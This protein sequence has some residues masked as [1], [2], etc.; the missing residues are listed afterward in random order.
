MRRL[1]TRANAAPFVT[2]QPSHHRRG[3]F[4]LL[5][6]VLALAPAAARAVLPD[7]IQVYANDINRSQDFGLELHLNTTP[8]GRSTP[9][10]PDEIPPAHGLRVTPELSWGL[11]RAFEAGLYLPFVHGAH[12]R[13]RFA[14]PKLRLKWL[15]LH[16][17]EGAA[18]LFGGVNFE[19]AWI[20]P[21]LEQATRQAE[22]RPIVGWRD[23]QWLI[24]LNP[25]LDFALAGAEQ[26][27]R[28]DFN[29]A[30]K[31]A[32]SVAQ[33]VAL[34]AEYYANLGKLNHFLPRASQSHTLYVALDVDRKPWVLN[35]GIGR[36]LT[37]FTDRWTVKAIF[38]IPF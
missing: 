33:G 29:P 2:G 13:D 35:F 20:S 23:E 17:E 9:D 34:G 15:P 8:S 7:E 14:G 32:R 31:I 38:E 4:A 18:G 37:A 5:A 24:A 25:I 11:T 30:L 6:A 28:P 10:F 36:G 19:Y 21:V 12:G 16:V 27:R 26:S 3:T 1:A 22:I